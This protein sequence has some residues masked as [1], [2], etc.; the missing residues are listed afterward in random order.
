MEFLI[1]IACNED[2]DQLHLKYR[3]LDTFREK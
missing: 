1:F 2:S 3:Q